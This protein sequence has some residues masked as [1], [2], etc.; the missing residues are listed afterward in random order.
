MSDEHINI[1]NDALPAYPGSILLPWKIL[2]VDDDDSVH[3]ATRFALEDFDFEGR[4]LNILSAHSAAEAQNVIAREEDI[5]VI[6][7]DVVMEQ[8]TIGLDLVHWIRN[9][10]N[11]DMMRIV[12]RTGQP[13][14]APELNVV[15]DY[16]INDYR[17]KSQM[18]AAKLATTVYSALRSYRDLHRLADQAEQLKDALMSAETAN[19]AKDKFITHM[20]HEFR[21]PLN[22]IIGLSEMIANETLGPLGNS[23][24][25]EY[26]WDIVDSGRQLQRMVESVLEFSEEGEFETLD[27]AEFDLRELIDDLP[28]L[29]NNAEGTERKR[30]RSR[31]K[32]N[33]D[34]EEKRLMLNADRNAVTAMLTNLI[35]NA[36][37]HNP[38]NCNVRVTAKQLERGGLLLTVVDDGRGISPEVVQNLGNP[39]NID[40]DPL[41]SGK[42]GLGLG[43]VATKTLIEKHGGA[44]TI[45]SN[46]MTGTKIYLRFPEG[47][48]VEHVPRRKKRDVEPSD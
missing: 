42:G 16:D 4:P 3:Q 34:K 28:N 45:A 24:Y 38:P 2:I 5:A 10:Q 31:V 41:L 46:A 40:G 22:G 7:L 1:I 6:L 8:E 18:T 19:R 35:S 37:K 9:D 29:R 30:K 13:G 20:S 21:T 48:V 36:L 33:P 11:D 23:K 44:M 39:F 15:R 17:E 25:K 26:A 43:L 12:L 32:E 14:F 47:S 27:I